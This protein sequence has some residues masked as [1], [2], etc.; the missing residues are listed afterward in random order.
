MLAHLLLAASLTSNSASPSTASTPEVPSTRFALDN[1]LE[2]LVHEDHRTP[3]IAVEIDRER[4]GTVRALP[5]RFGTGSSRL[6][7]LWELVFFDLPLDT[8]GTL[9]QE[10]GAVDEAAV[11]AAVAK[12]LRT[13]DLMVVVAGDQAKVLPEL[14]ALAKDGQFGRNGLVVI[15]ADGKRVSPDAAGQR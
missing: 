2:V 4:A 1:G 15:D 5:G 9:P 6:G 10:V 11:R 14:E 3:V 8:Y 13:D 12:H 7:S